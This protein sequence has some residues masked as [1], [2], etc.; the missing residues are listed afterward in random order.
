MNTLTV[1]NEA[2]RLEAL[3]QYQILD[4]PPEQVFDDLAF[5][6]AQICGTAIAVINLID[7]KR[8]WF[9]AKIGLDVQQMPR[10]IGFCPFCIEEEDALVIPDTLADK[11]YASASV[12]TSEPYVRFYAGIPLITPSGE[13]IG[14]LCVVD[15]K[16][17][18]INDEQ[19]E[20]LKAISR[21]IIRQLEIRRNLTELA[22]IK[23][24]YKQ[25]KE[26]LRQSECTLRSF[27]DSA[28]MMMG[29]VE[30][31][32][33]DIRHISDNAASAK[34]F[35]FTPKGMKNRFA[36][37]MG[38]P[39]KYVRQWINHYRQAEKT[40]SPVSFEYLH[41]TRDA[42][43]WLRATVSSITS[44]CH[45]PLR[46]AYIV[47]DITERKQAEKERLQILAREQATQ[48]RIT[49]I[50]ASIADGFFALDNEWRFTYI[51]KQA[52]PLLQRSKEELLGRNIWDEFPEAVDSTFYREYH[53]SITQQISVEFEEFYLPFDAWFAIH[54]YP[55][56]EGLY[57]YFR[58]ITKRKQAEQKVREQ[59]AL[60]DIS[61][62][63]IV[64][65][66]LSK[67]ILLWN[68]SAEKLYGWKAEEAIGKNI[69]QFDNESFPQQEIYKIVLSVGNWQGE[70]QK[71]TKSGK[72]IIVESRWTL[73]RDEHQKAKS[74]LIVD[75]DI[76]QKKQIE[77]QFLRAQ[78]M[79][80]LGT[81]A[82]GIAHDLNNMLSPILM[83]VPLLK[84]KLSDERSVKVLSIVENNAK[85]G[86]NLVKQVLS[87]A[88]GIEGDRT[89]LQLKHQILEMKQIMEQTFP[90]SITLEK[91]IQPDLWHI[92]GDST[93]IHQVLMNLCVNARD[94]MPNGGTLNISAKN[95]FIDEN[96]ARM[97]LDAKVGYYIL[98]SVAD[99]GIGISQEIL[100][101][102][103]EPFFTTKEFGKGTG[104]GL[105][106]VMGI[107]KGH[108][109]FITV[110][111]AIAKG[112]KFQ[113]YF[114]A[115]NTD[116]IREEENQEILTGHEELILIVD[117]EASIRE[118]TTTSLEKYNYKAITASDGIEAIALYAQHKN[119]I[120]AA[121]IDI[122]MPNMDGAT[123]IKTL[124]KMN[125]LL[126][127][128]AVSGLP[129]S[130]QVLLNKT[131]QHAAFLPKPYTTQELLQSLYQ[132]IGHGA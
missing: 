85:R 11:R 82:S 80:S 115:M 17:R 117:D 23:T 58:D 131:S 52:E 46:F 89:V 34:F 88:R 71:Q 81:L 72:K 95:I 36:S 20:G 47:E 62:D 48:N 53:S 94:A 4:T 57:V 45:S 33:D 40:R 78:R 61:T 121:I 67:K 66:D 26:E 69:N 128:I 65:R 70:L 42:N 92:C 7:S 3:R 73:V 19:L 76:T 14:T 96:F 32:Y 56:K 113:I 119:E 124:K 108:G 122:M 110:S 5:L 15:Q 84:A 86:A 35:G 9:K 63:A 28:P 114:P 38:M 74:I 16:P 24:D 50:F 59:A 13:A 90:K 49:N 120:K 51:N 100:E 103:F 75:T 109:G 126:P 22:S 116:A 21:L 64:V 2:R 6:A 93:Q 104:L 41:E 27:F 91:E 127:I 25:A 106:T 118:I 107:V 101:R 111:S 83:S 105:S 54:A 129:T 99:T 123:T 18:Q 44:C 79:E 37:N 8:H 1:K 130:E 125:P 29:T 12:V 112:T 39:Q 87:F 60:L 97:H 55:S 43:K 102:I 10:D 31:R 77:T 98:L 68:K 30:L 132:I